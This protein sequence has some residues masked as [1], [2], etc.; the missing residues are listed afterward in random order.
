MVTHKSH[1]YTTI[2]TKIRRYDNARGHPHAHM[3]LSNTNAPNAVLSAAVNALRCLRAPGL[4]RRDEL[5]N[6]LG[7]RASRLPDAL[8][9]G[10]DDKGEET[11]THDEP[12]LATLAQN[13]M[14]GLVVK[15]PVVDEGIF[16]RV[17]GKQYISA[18]F[19]P[20]NMKLG[21]RGLTSPPMMSL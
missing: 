6:L 1:M 12:L 9:E 18:H 4:V 19:P 16:L 15:L 17:S 8:I 2:H 10:G 21:G 11:L 7:D 20:R 5:L 13:Y 3:S 14:T